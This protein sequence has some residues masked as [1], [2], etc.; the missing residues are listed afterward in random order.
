MVRVVLRMALFVSVL[1]SGVEIHLTTTAPHVDVFAALLNRLVQPTSLEFWTT[2]KCHNGI[3]VS[4]GTT[5]IRVLNVTVINYRDWNWAN[6]DRYITSVQLRNLP[7]YLHRYILIEECVMMKLYK[8]LDDLMYLFQHTNFILITD[9]LI[10][11]GRI[12]RFFCFTILLIFDSN[13]KKSVS[14][15]GLPEE[16]VDQKECSRWRFYDEFNLTSSGVARFPWLRNIVAPDSSPKNA[17]IS[18]SCI[19]N[20]KISNPFRILSQK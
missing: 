10:E 15:F 16:S 18:G 20:C 6:I 3:D 5:T 4:V 8:H 7:S 2:E 9:S 17:K 19:L 14:L 11:T 13:S 1:L 12:S